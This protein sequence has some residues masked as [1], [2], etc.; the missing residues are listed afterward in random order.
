[1]AATAKGKRKRQAE[2]GSNKDD[3]EPKGNRSEDSK[4]TKLERLLNLVKGKQH[5]EDKDGKCRRKRQ[6]RIRKEK[7]KEKLE[8]SVVQLP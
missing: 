5:E 1:M 6:Q 2:L 7:R 8:R 3:A 4:A